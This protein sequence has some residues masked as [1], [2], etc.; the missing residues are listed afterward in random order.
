MYLLLFLYLIIFLFGVGL[1]SKQR[2]VPVTINQYF[3]W[4]CFTVTHKVNWIRWRNVG[5]YR[6]ATRVKRKLTPDIYITMR[7]VNPPSINYRL[8]VLT[9]KI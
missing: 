5:R 4:Y 1:E 6:G 9:D 2:D 8:Y 3:E 7:R